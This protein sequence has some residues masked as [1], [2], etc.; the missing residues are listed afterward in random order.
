MDELGQNLFAR[1][2]FAKDQNRDVE[3]GRPVDSLADGLHGVRRAEID[4]LRRQFN[5]VGRYES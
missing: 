2:A 5:R 3:S 4:V 1:P